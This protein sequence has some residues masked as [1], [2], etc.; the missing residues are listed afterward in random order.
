MRA[1]ELAERLKSNVLDLCRELLPNGRVNNNEYHAGSVDGE[2]GKSLSIRISGPKIGVWSDFADNGTKGDLIGLISKTKNLNLKDSCSYAENF[3]GL[4]KDKVQFQVQPVLKKYARPK[5]TPGLSTKHIEYLN[6]RK[7]S[8]STITMFRVYVDINGVRVCFPSYVE[9]ELYR[10]KSLKIE[11]LDGKKEMVVTPSTEPCLFGWQALDGT[12]RRIII[13][14]GEIDAMSWYEYGYPALSVPMG[15]GNHQWIESDFERL[16][17]FDEILI[18]FDE[19]SAGIKGA[20]EVIER[21]GADRCRQ[22]NLPYKDCNECL[23]CGVSK[24]IIDNLVYEAKNCD[25]TDIK[26]PDFYTDKILRIFHPHPEDFLG[27]DLPWAKGEFIKFRPNE[28]S[29]WG[30]INGHGKTI[31]L[32]QIMIDAI[33][34]GKKC[35]I[36]S[37]EVNPEIMLSDMMLQISGGKIQPTKPYCLKMIKY[38]QEG[39]FIFDPNDYSGITTSERL[40]SGFE[41][42]NKKYGVDQFLID[43]L[44]TMDINE[45]D[46]NKQKEFMRTL[47]SFRKKFSCHIHL[48]TH[49]RKQKDENFPVNKMDIMGTSSISN[50]PD[51]VF[52]VSRNKYKEGLLDKEKNNLLTSEEKE[53]IYSIKMQPDAF[54]NCVKQRRTGKEGIVPLWFDAPSKQFTERD[55]SMAYKIYLEEHE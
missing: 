17:L 25:P 29:V 15:A 36:A 8:D 53:A 19:D 10:I 2:P 5:M 37:M 18:S 44:M 34:K 27:L 42:V 7:I 20:Q 11:R 47:C 24:E 51:N 43:S 32:C 38:M 45:E 49:I 26:T 50:L 55:G 13:C 52:I 41:Y 54:L 3:L 48:V 33:S 21:L 14:E 31:M 28:L 1:N 30:G 16:E 9:N 22:I 40:L 6:N 4:S 12:E 23:M 46:Y 39:L 35:C